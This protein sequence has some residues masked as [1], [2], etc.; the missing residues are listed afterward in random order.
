M[1]AAP[2]FTSAVSVSIPLLRIRILKMT[3]KSE[4]GHRHIEKRALTL[5]CLTVLGYPK[6]PK[7][8]S[9]AGKS[10]QGSILGC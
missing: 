10:K 2:S 4:I 7:G 6:F 9:Q 5:L 3:S 8:N 1:T